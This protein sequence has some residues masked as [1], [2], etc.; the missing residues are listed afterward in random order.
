MATN[1]LPKL[2]VLLQMILDES[3]L[4]L[5]WDGKTDEVTLVSHDGVAITLG[6]LEACKLRDCLIKMLPEAQACR[7]RSD[8]I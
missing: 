1:S 5:T 8:C 2:Q 7:M 4:V 6:F 3:K